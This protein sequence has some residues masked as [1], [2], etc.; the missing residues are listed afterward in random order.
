MNRAD[1]AYAIVGAMYPRSGL[2]LE[3]RQHLARAVV[4]ILSGRD[5][6]YFD[7]RIRD[8]HLGHAR[9]II[10][11]Q[12]PS[13][14]CEEEAAPVELESDVCIMQRG[15]GPKP[16]W[17]RIV[18]PHCFTSQ[19]VKSSGLRLYRLRHDEFL[20]FKCG[21][22][23]EPIRLEGHGGMFFNAPHADQPVTFMPRV[24]L[25]VT[26]VGPVEESS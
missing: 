12:L 11:E 5:G 7:G 3:T 24:A 13:D 16:V 20:S 17:L 2:P 23:L 19:N 6:T 14:P 10:S 22:C 26:A 1:R 9:E 15:L 8:E 25:S 21:N 18:C 4:D